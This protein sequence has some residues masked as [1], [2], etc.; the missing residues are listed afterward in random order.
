MPTRRNCEGRMN[1]LAFDRLTS[2]YGCL[3]CKKKFDKPWIIPSGKPQPHNI[4]INSEVLFHWED[5]HGFPADMLVEMIQE[6]LS[7]PTP[8]YELIS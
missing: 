5:T 7:C 6:R 2:I 4:A 3:Q 8:L 1:I